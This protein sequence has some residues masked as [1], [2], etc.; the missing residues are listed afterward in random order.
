MANEITGQEQLRQVLA[1]ARTM[2]VLG[3]HPRPE[4]PAHYV[5][6]YLA[7]QGWRVIP[8]NPRFAGTVLFGEPVLARLADVP[9]PVDL[10]DVFR[11]SEDLMA[12]L[13][14]IL[15]MP[16]RPKCVWLQSGIVNDDFARALVEAGID[17]VQDEC[18]YALHRRFGLSPVAPR[19]A[20]P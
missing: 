19:A 18:T 2:A 9:I 10:L 7:Q 12:H 15:A 3:A 11:R 14:E 13:P 8:V 5:P 6:R 1:A 17:V 20:A 4:R 16:H